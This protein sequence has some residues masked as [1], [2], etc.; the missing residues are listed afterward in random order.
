MDER[1]L[2]VDPFRGVNTELRW[3]EKIGPSQKPSP[4]RK[5]S[6]SYYQKITHET[7]VIVEPNLLYRT[8][9][10]TLIVYDGKASD[11]AVDPSG[12]LDPYLEARRGTRIATLDYEVAV[13]IVTITNWE[14]PRWHDA[15]P[16]REAFK[17]MRNNLEDCVQKIIVKDR[18][19]SFW[20]SL[21]FVHENKG[22]DF[23]VYTPY[24]ITSTELV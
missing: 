20:R 21:G 12:P 8:Q 13:N 10:A 14:H 7:T 3:W 17:V 11:P 19:D 18:P 23:L 16:V 1:G 22:D 15:T 5:T 2:T 4:Y 9:F 6:W 24:L